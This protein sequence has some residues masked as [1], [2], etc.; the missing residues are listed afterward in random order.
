M[1]NFNSEAKIIPGKKYPSDCFTI[2]LQLHND[3]LPG[4]SSS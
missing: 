4:T 2:C 1:I 3:Q